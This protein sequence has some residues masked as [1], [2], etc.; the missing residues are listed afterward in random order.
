MW[1]MRFPQLRRLSLTIMEYTRTIEDHDEGM[2]KFLEVH[3]SIE[4][5]DF[6]L[7]WGDR[8]GESFADHEF[9]DL[10]ARPRELSSTEFLPNLRIFSGLLNAFV[11]LARH[12]PGC[13]RNLSRLE[14]MIPAFCP[15]SDIIA[16]LHLLLKEGMPRPL[17]L[18]LK[19][20]KTGI[21]RRS[22]TDYRAVYAKFAEL[23]GTSVEIWRIDEVE[24]MWL[25]VKLMAPIFA[26]FEN[27]KEIHME[28]DSVDRRLCA[29]DD[30]GEDVWD[31]D[32]QDLQ[33]T[34]QIAEAY[35][36][37][38]AHVCQK[39]QKVVMFSYPALQFG[40]ERL[41]ANGS[42]EIC[43]HISDSTETQIFPGEE[44][45]WAC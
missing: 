3:P 22:I 41:H 7:G 17:L 28:R 15:S 26:C 27:L 5:L 16:M 40:I 44:W 35:V 19:D 2:G 43:V 32:E 45:K 21:E 14:L 38:L 12:R 39:L 34:A 31:D 37:K 18:A 24:E 29:A 13:L 42:E 8:T 11:R 23:F 25:P 20:F 9:Q 36:R 4:E 1:E 30:F 10:F 6:T 33:D